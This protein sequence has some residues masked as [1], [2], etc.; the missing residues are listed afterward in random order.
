M[1]IDAKEF[2]DGWRATFGKMTLG[3]VDGLNCLLAEMEGR[4]WGDLRWWAYV[5]ATAFHET[6]G[7]MQP[8]KETVAASHKNKNPSDATVI[9]RLNRAW[10]AGKLTWV[11]QPYWLGGWFGRGFVQLTH[12]RNYEKLGQALG[13]D[14]AGNPDLAL[15]PA[16]AAAI[17]CEGMERGLFTGRSLPQFFSDKVDDPRNARKIV[18]GLE[19]AAAIEEIYNR[20][21]PIVQTAVSLEEE[22]EPMPNPSLVS[23]PNSV[24]TRKMFSVMLAGAATVFAQAVVPELVPI[25]MATDA[26]SAAQPWVAPILMSVAGYMTRE[27][28]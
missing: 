7:M 4:E 24:P 2:F 25:L 5:L 8:I 28:R 13:T 11:Q 3:E 27:S 9:A 1:K 21:L 6:G 14:L 20:I 12:E 26:W 23:Q 10:H 18:N 16:I 15:D 19:S 17:I 22:E